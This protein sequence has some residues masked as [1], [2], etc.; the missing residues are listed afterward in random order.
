MTQK[1]RRW[2][3]SLDSSS[4]RFSVVHMGCANHG[5]LR[6]G[7]RLALID[8]YTVTPCVEEAVETRDDD[9]TEA[10]SG[11]VSTLSAASDLYWTR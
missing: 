6:T 2:S 3:Y 5:G 10:A 4:S 1:G 7:R 8:L 11:D 9:S